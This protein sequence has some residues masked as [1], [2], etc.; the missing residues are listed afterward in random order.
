M[1]L[2]EAKQSQFIEEMGDLIGEH[3][4][5][6]MAGR[7]IG[8]L[9]ICSPSFMSLDQLAD[10]LQASK[11]AI[12]MSTQ[13]LLR[14]GMLTRVSVPGDRKHYLEI[15]PRIGENLFLD[16]SDHIE[17]HLSVIQTG[18][19]AVSDEP[20]EARERLIEMK[21]FFEFLLRELP[22]I[23]DRWAKQR[24]VLLQNEMNAQV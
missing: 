4:L 6:H 13:L 1:D 17:Q 21:V 22:G 24:S 7:V 14:L 15:R 2:Q 16:R 9:M 20:I 19:D 12:S 5:P 10:M 8:A 18:L 11:G 23:A 3:G